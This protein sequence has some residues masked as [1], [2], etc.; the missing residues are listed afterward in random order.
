LQE[1]KANW[2]PIEGERPAPGQLVRLELSTIENG[3]VGKPQ[4]YVIVLGEGHAVPALEEKVMTLLPGET[5]DAEVKYPD[6]HPDEAKRGTARQV[7]V[8]LQEVKRKELPPLDDAFAR[9]VGEFENLEALR[10]AIREDLVKEGTRDADRQV[11]A[12]LLQQLA[13][14]N[15][16]EAPPSMVERFTRAYARAYEIPEARLEG[17]RTEFRPV[18]EAQVRRDLILDTVAEAHQLRATEAELD[19]R[20]AA[21]A[22]GRNLPAAQLYAQLEKAGRLRELERS[23]TEE[24]AFAWLLQQST[25]VDA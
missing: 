19:E 12:D 16:V 11:R 13:Q 21:L 3:E 24:K 5:A 17:F 25:V 9:E 18:A 4:P 2:L 15:N 14:A 10:A 1:Q 22:A 23:I 8:T 7:R 6:D 20:I